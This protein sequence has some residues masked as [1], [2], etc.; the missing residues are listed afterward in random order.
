MGS[1]GE[2]KG[3]IQRG[4]GRD[5]GRFKIT[6]LGRDSGEIRRRFGGNRGRGEIQGYAGKKQG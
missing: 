2:I 5:T 1:T 4:Y 6:D 3:E